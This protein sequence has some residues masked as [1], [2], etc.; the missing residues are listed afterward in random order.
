MCEGRFPGSPSSGHVCEKLRQAT[1]CTG[2]S[3]HRQICRGRGL[4]PL[5]RIVGYLVAAVATVIAASASGFSGIV[6]CDPLRE[7]VTASS[8]RFGSNSWGPLLV[9]GPWMVASL[10]ILQS[11]LHRHRVADS[12]CVVLFFSALAVALCIAQVP[13][14]LPDISVVALPAI[15]AMTGFQQLVRQ[16]A[17]ARRL[18]GDAVSRHH[19]TFCSS[20]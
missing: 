4:L 2:P 13:R 7:V 17:R 6:A 14:N 11:A 19:E 8:A 1:L 5:L 9:Y 18:P 15:G 3:G 20:R 16:I 10:S 12:C